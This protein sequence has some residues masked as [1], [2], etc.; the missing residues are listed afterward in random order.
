MLH[1]L[2]CAS[3]PRSVHS[4]LSA[5]NDLH[6][7]FAPVYVVVA[8]FLAHSLSVLKSPEVVTLL[9]FTD[10]IMQHTSFVQKK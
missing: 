7:V 8:L 9:P 10:D 3:A 5:G 1:L 6:M 2:F 4:V